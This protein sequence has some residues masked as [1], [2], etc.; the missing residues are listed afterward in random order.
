[1]GENEWASQDERIDRVIF[2]WDQQLD[3]VAISELLHEPEWWVA[4]MLRIGL[5]RRR[6]RPK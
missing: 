1:M 3:T 2:L 4:R 5:N 6:E